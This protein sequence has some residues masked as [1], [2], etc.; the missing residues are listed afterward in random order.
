MRTTAAAQGWHCPWHC[1]QTDGIFPSSG[2]PQRAALLQEP[3]AG[4]VGWL[5]SEEQTFSFTSPAKLKGAR[6]SLWLCRSRKEEESSAALGTLGMAALLRM[7]ALCEPRVGCVPA[8]KEDRGEEDVP[9]AAPVL[10][11]EAARL[12]HSS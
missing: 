4:Q 6:P 9:P 10:C 11:L 5:P 2:L 8:L 1:W 7:G 3:H 12:Y